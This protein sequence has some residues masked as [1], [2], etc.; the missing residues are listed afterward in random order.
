M[1]A[2]YVHMIMNG[3][4][5]AAQRRFLKRGVIR[6]CLT[7]GLAA[8]LGLMVAVPVSAAGT[9]DA[10]ETAGTTSAMYVFGG[11][12][13]LAQTFTA[14]TTGSLDQVALPLGTMWNGAGAIYIVPLDAAG[15]P[16]SMTGTSFG[17]YRGA[18]TC[19][20]VFR[21]YAIAPA[22]Q[23]TAN[24]HYALVVV[25]N[26]GTSVTWA[27]VKSA[28]YDYP[29]GQLWYGNQPSTWSYNTSMGY[30][31]DFITYVT[32][33]GPAPGPTPGPSNT[34]P[35]IKA[36]LDAVQVTE[37]AV[38]T[39]GGT[40][41]DPDGD[42]VALSAS[43]LTGA[44]G[45]VTAGAAGTWSWKGAAA[46]EGQGQT[47]TIT[48]DDGHGNKATAQFSTVV[49]SVLPTAKISGAPTS[50]REGTTIALTA[51]ATSPSAEDTAAGFTFN[52]TATE[53]G[54]NLP[55]ASGSSYALKTDDEG[56]YVIKLTATDEAGFTSPAVSVTINGVDVSP[57]ASI[58]GVPQGFVIVP[59]QTLTFNGTFTDAGSVVDTSYTTTWSWGDGSPNS[60]G[61]SATHVY[62]SGGT[63]TVVLTAADDD[64]VAGSAS[65][66]VTV[67]TPAAALAKI[68]A[69]VSAQSGLNKG[70]M[71]SLLA[72]LNA[73]ADSW[74]RGNTGATCNQ[75]NA[76]VNEVDA[77][78][79]TGR[80][81]GGD[82]ATMT[83][84]TRLTQRS[85][86]CFRTLVEFLSGL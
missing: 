79:K 26:I 17:T 67:L 3:R 38:P 10:Q 5:Q 39:A 29:G 65:T 31:F 69:L 13:M 54:N 52:W 28:S 84:A 33:S 61:N 30:D 80:I 19:C 73:A 44:A 71:N 20:S 76:F 25:P 41:S 60:A 63:Y 11:S 86:G 4:R 83:E 46:D 62:A 68:T 14:V 58:T 45:T 70:Q 23:V 22:Y 53:Y 40:Y 18:M 66:T 59:Q 51:S 43:A 42:T 81:S 72:K 48:A 6:R 37:G 27:V 2:P 12:S 55:G 85:M 50:V 82:A 8:V 49:V 7:L 9:P 74:Q 15:K 47:I 64:G 75:L 32:S 16:S 34:P 35:T 77:D 36:N 56:V 1:K 78:Q 24:S 21:P 57:A